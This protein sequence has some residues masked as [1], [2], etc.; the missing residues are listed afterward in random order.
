MN[1]YY[2]KDQLHKLGFK[3]LGDNVL[4]SKK[5]SI[6][7]AENISIANNVRIDDFVIL[8]GYIDIG[9]FVHISTGSVLMSK[10]EGIILEDYSC[11]SIQC[12]VLGSSDD[13]TGEA[14]VGPC[15]P[16]QYRHITSKPI[17]LKKYSLLGCNSIILPGGNLAE[18]VSV[19]AASLIL[20]PTKAW[21]IYFG[22]P[23]KRIAERSKNLLKLE[24][25]FSALG[26][27]ADKL[28]SSLS[29]ISLLFSIQ[30]SA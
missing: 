30:K 7:N 14:L 4:L 22:T 9:S 19:G 2:T 23:A 29:S 10:E 18:G 21:G 28:K 24:E 1:S 6:Y 15:I 12:K 26:G 5:A 11:V 27:G 17:I 8:S 3:S 20:R 13:F 25:E 16:L